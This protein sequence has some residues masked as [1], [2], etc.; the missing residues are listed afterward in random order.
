MIMLLTLTIVIIIRGPGATGTAA[1][2]PLRC[3]SYSEYSGTAGQKAPLGYVKSALRE[4]L[5]IDKKV[6]RG[7]K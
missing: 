1:P 3:T 4:K 2:P 6:I 5:N 7:Y